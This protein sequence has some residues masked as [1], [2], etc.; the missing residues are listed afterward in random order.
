MAITKPAKEE[1]RLVALDKYAILDTDPEQLEFRRNLIL[2]KEAFTDRT[3]EEHERQQE[4]LHV[5]ETLMREMGLRQAPASSQS[6]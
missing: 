3:K 2:L 4:F 1:A 6:L 5:Q